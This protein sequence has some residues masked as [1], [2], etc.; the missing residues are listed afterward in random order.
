MFYEHQIGE[1]HEVLFE[2]AQDG[3]WR[4]YTGNYTRVAAKSEEDLKNQVRQ[5]RLVQL[6]GDL[7]EGTLY[8]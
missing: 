4:G 2:Q 1:T 6:L 7:I 3:S 8:N 5:L